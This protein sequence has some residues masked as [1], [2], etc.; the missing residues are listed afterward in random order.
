MSERP[1]VVV[2][3]SGGVDSSVAAALL[4]DQGYPVVGMMLRLWSEEGCEDENRCCTPDAMA[5]AR[6]VAAILGIP[7]YAVDGRER[8][9]ASV[10]QDFLEGYQRGLTPNPCIVCNRSVR[11]GY[12]LEQV[13]ATGAEYMATGHYARLRQT[14]TGTVALLRARDERKDQ[15][16]VLSG[17]NQSQL[18]HTLLPLGEYTKPEVRELAR[19]YRLPVAERPDSQDLCFL[20]QGDYRSFLTRHM[21]E[22]VRPGPI[23]TRG[24]RV[25]GEH[26]GLAFY[27]IGQRKG[28]G[29]AS[30]LPLYVLQKDLEG[31]RLVVGVESE[32][33]QQSMHVRAINWIAGEAP[34]ENF[35]AEVKIRYKAAFAQA[36]VF[37]LPGDRA[38][39]VLA[40]PARD[41]TPGQ[42]AVFYDGEIVIGSGWIESPA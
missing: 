42:L 32:L 40:E 6:R 25:L 5:Q 1:S 27:T 2:A 7:F 23:V 34:A 9:R 41:I 17:L 20:G 26:Q 18:A 19:K 12:L 28:L 37:P 15:S 35:V 30:A 31:N 11:W 39:V 36:T 22:A 24:G 4:V 38:K 3:M 33:G 13:Q 14:P 8:F 10:V 16:Y 29:V 21:P